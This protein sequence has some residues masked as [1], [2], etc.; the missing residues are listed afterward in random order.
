MYDHN[1]KAEEAA[2]EIEADLN[3][4]KGLQ[5]DDLDD[6]V[7]ADI[8]QQWKMLLAP[9]IKGAYDQGVSDG[10]DGAVGETA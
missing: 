8:L 3:N 9:F 2:H 6:E 7:H 4:R 5:I 10:I 1:K